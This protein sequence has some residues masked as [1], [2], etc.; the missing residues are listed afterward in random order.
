MSP[1]AY[2]SLLAEQMGQKP[3]QPNHKRRAVLRGSLA[4]PVVLTVSSPAAAVSSLRRCLN[5]QNAQN[6]EPFISASADTWLRKSVDV[7]K[8]EKSEGNDKDNAKGGGSDKKTTDWVYF[9]EGLQDYV[10]V[11]APHRRQDIGPLT[12]GWKK[13]ATEKRWG[14]V[15]VEENSGEPYSKVQI[16]RPTGYTAC[17]NSCFTSFRSTRGAG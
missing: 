5:N 7:H 11:A 8:F 2:S 14:L 4:A 17:T 1:R 3:S 13:V 15:W 16:Q 12:S 6:A 9:D 10:T